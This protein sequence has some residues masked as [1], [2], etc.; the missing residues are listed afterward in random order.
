MGSQTSK[1]EFGTIEGPTEEFDR[2]AVLAN[3][4]AK[5]KY[6]SSKSRPMDSPCYPEGEDDKEARLHWQTQMQ[7]FLRQHDKIVC[8]A[9]LAVLWSNIDPMGRGVTRRHAF[10]FATSVRCDFC[11]LVRA[12]LATEVDDSLKG[13]LSSVV[14][15]FLV[16]SPILDRVYHEVSLH[17][18]RPY[19]FGWSIA[20]GLYENTPTTPNRW[21]RQLRFFTQDDDVLSLRIPG[22]PIDP[23]GNGELLLRR[24]VRW[25][26]N[27]S[28]NHKSCQW[29]SDVIEDPRLPARVI[30]I[31]IPNSQDPRLITT[32]GKR[33][34]WA[35]LSHRWGNVITTSNESESATTGNIGNLEDRIPS[36]MLSKTFQDAIQI[37]R[38]LGLRYLWIDRLCILQD[39]K[40]DWIEQSA[41]MPLTYK[42]AHVTI[43]AGSSKDGTGGIFRDRLWT[44]L[45]QQLDLPIL[46]QQGL[47]TV[48]VDIDSVDLVSSLESNYLQSRAWCFQEAQL[49]RRRLV[50]DREQTSFI[51]LQQGLQE[52]WAPLRESPPTDCFGFVTSESWVDRRKKTRQQSQGLLTQDKNHLL[53]QSLSLLSQYPSFLRKTAMLRTWYD[54]ITDYSGR[55]LTFVSDK[56]VAIAGVA[57]LVGQALQDEYR[58]GIWVFSLPKSLLWSPHFKSFS[59]MDDTYGSCLRPSTYIAPSWSW[60]ALCGKIW[61]PLCDI[62]TAEGQRE[63]LATVLDIFTD[64]SS[65]GPYG[66]VSTGYLRI[67][68]HLSRAFLHHEAPKKGQKERWPFVSLTPESRTG[69]VHCIPDVPSEIH[70]NSDEKFWVLQ[71]TD[72]DGLLL[73]QLAESENRYSRIG[74]FTSWMIERCEP[75]QFGKQH[76]KTITLV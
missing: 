19:I 5:P 17:E 1:T 41:Q 70:P 25:V 27:C 64:A 10:R 59:S 48:S 38:T 71:I 53:Y 36:K 30:D 3:W 76:L 75:L 57:E 50:F 20:A 18:I 23:A 9:C 35:A 29:S 63:D 11:D 46:C 7:P 39:S 51:C 49:S 40:S 8:D 56:L 45:S 12:L 33:G 72:K 31:G 34:R 68:G 66:T 62:S 74:I 69:G 24:I 73:L 54:M 32:N 43:A 61:F 13:D 14:S 65:M 52:Q 21:S 15:G 47:S 42:N 2:A 37:T 55:D 28:S 4:K 26:N 60:A 67:R 6:I 44:K 58:A 22:R 16:M